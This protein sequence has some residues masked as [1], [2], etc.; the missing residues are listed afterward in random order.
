MTEHNGT[1]AP[2]AERH[3]GDLTTIDIEALDR[4]IEQA[5]AEPEDREGR[6]WQINKMLAEDDR[7]EVG[8][9]CSYHLQCER[10]RLKPWDSPP[11]HSNGIGR[12]P[13]AR[14]RKRLE[15]AGLSIFEPD[16]EAAL[17]EFAS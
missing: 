2:W 13:S 4:A 12:S 15:K 17:K 10:L 1:P 9:F 16:P 6:H 11:M 5:L 7:I 3:I 8:M 14:L